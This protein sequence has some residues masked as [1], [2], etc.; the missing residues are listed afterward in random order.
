MR[1]ISWGKDECSPIKKKMKGTADAA[2]WV[3]S[4]VFPAGA[5]ARGE[6]KLR[7]FMAFVDAAQGAAISWMHIV[8]YTL[9][10]TIRL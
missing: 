4:K 9:H 3:H 2:S 6:K 7:C 5:A 1:P 10:N 8:Q